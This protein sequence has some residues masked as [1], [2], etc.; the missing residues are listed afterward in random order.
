MKKQLLILLSLLM[1][2]A[3]S[4]CMCPSSG[5]GGDDDY[6]GYDGYDGGDDD[7]DTYYDDDFGDDDNTYDDDTY[8]DDTYDDDTYDDDTYDDDTYDDDT[9]D[10]DT[11]DDDTYDDDEAPVLSD[12]GWDPTTTIL[13]EFEGYDEPYYYSALFWSVCDLDND[14]LGGQVFVY[15]SGT[16]DPFLTGDLYWADLN[17][18]PDSD[19]GNAGDCGSPVQTGINILFAPQS[20]PTQAPPGTYCCDIEASDDLGNISNLLT[21]L[22][23]THDP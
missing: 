22:C 3:L 9:Y 8:D 23:V 15:V 14:L 13:G 4:T 19:L 21:N 20:N 12:G 10:D 17:N 7:N 1:V 16:T 5:G 6:D 18:P 2:L 11:Y